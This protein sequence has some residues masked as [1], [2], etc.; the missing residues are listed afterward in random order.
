[1]TSSFVFSFLN[2]LACNGLLTLFFAEH[3]AKRI[4]CLCCIDF[5]DRREFFSS[6]RTRDDEKLRAGKL[7]LYESILDATN[8]G[9]CFF[10]FGYGDEAYK[11]DY[12]WSYVTNNVVAL[13]HDLHPKQVSDIF[14]LYEEVM[15]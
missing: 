12:D 14:P 10:D 5:K 15:L 13:F 4:A 1:M 9:L 8:E 2:K 7:L 6:G 3:Q 11:S